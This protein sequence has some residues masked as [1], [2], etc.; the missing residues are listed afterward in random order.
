MGFDSLL[1]N[2]QLRENL[3]SS[4]RRG[5]FSHFYLICGPE[6]AGKHTLAGLLA[7]AAVCTGEEKPCGSCSGCR[8]AAAGMH[9]DVI[10]VDD[11][12]KKTVSVELIRKAKADIYIRPNEAERKVYVIP[13]AQD[14]GP[15]AQNALLK[16]LEEPP[17]YGVFLLLTDNPEKLLPTVRSRCTE[18][19]LH[20]IP[21]AQ[22]MGILQKQYPDAQTDTLRA[23]A[24]RSGGY[25]GQARALLEEGGSL[26]EHALRF[27][28]AYGER[29]RYA[30]LQ[31]LAPMEKWKRDQ[32]IAALEQWRSLVHSAL[33]CR[34]GVDTPFPAARR[35]G[36]S[37][38]PA[39][40]RE[41][42]DR[43]KKVTEYAQGN[44]S[45]AAI[46][47]YLIWSLR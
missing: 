30:L 13:R 16:V 36:E 23:V 17:A 10:T 1:G 44:V 46:C 41:T 39:E 22:L 40:L 12:E 5:R 24:V 34:S 21:E 11:P 37:R 26:P 31:V 6:G 29:D 4:I 42:V 35:L 38:S 33:L 32:L 15:A 8:K 28:R 43:L 19:R 14:M 45:P 47:G 9:P 2:E 18:L 25:L 7:S 27:L 20:A 3:N